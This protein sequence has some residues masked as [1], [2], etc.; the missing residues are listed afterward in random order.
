MA[1]Q[2]LRKIQSYFVRPSVQFCRSAVKTEIFH[3]MIATAFL[4]LV[5]L[6]V[7]LWWLWNE[8]SNKYFK[9]LNVPYLPAPMLG[10]HL[11]EMILQRK[12]MTDVIMDI[13]NDPK[14]KAA[15]AVGVRFLHKHGLVIK[16]LELLKRILIKD[17]NN[18]QDRRTNSDIRYDFVGGANI[19]MLKNVDEAWKNVRAKITPV[20]TGTKMKQLFQ[21]VDGV[22]RDLTEYLDRTIPTETEMDVK[23]I[24]ALYT[25]DV[26]ATCGYGVQANSFKDPHSDFRHH[27]EKIFHFNTRRSIEYGLLFFWPEAGRYLRMK[28]FSKE[29]T[30]FLTDT[31]IEVMDEREKNQI[32]RN[33]LIDV[34]LTLRKGRREGQKDAV[35]Y[36]DLM[37]V[38]Q[39]AVFFTAG[40]EPTS[41]A[42]G[43]ML[44]ELAKE[45]SYILF[46]QKEI[47]ALEMIYCLARSSSE[48]RTGTRN[49]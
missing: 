45:V 2:P 38:A 23:D 32:M 14:T 19:F 41:S 12:A 25:T 42:I 39:A 18:F 35:D 46:T 9:K 29:S 20:F 5:L 1:S 26:I 22:G 10:G 31:L 21:L 8:N 33:D 24:A 11:K 47:E 49:S 3:E 28:L 6:I 34:L 43:F 40:F 4:G 17:F 15:P 48:R 30:K 27:G 36:D 37:L 7:F 13:Y 44:Y 16:D